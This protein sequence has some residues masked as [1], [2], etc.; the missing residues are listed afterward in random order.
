MR[1]GNVRSPNADFHLMFVDNQA[2]H[3]RSEAILHDAA[4]A[5]AGHTPI[6]HPTAQMPTREEA[7]DRIR[8][9]SRA[10]S[11]MGSV[12]Y[13]GDIFGSQG[14][15]SEG[16]MY[17]ARRRSFTGSQP[18]GSPGSPLAA[19][20]AASAQSATASSSSSSSAA[21][22]SAVSA[23][24]GSPLARGV[25]I[26]MLQ[27]AHELQQDQHRQ[28][29]GTTAAH[30]LHEHSAS[31]GSGAALQPLSDAPLHHDQHQ[32]QHQQQHPQSHPPRHPGGGTHGTSSDSASALH[33]E[34]SKRGHDHPQ[35]H[36]ASQ[37]HLQQ[38]QQ[39]QRNSRH[40][41]HESTGDSR[42]SNRDVSNTSAF[43]LEKLKSAEEVGGAKLLN[44]EFYHPSDTISAHV[45]KAL[46][47]K[48]KKQPLLGEGG[49]DHASAAAGGLFPASHHSDDSTL[50]SILSTAGMIH[51]E[52]NHGAYGG[53]IGGGHGVQGYLPV[54]AD[55][56]PSSASASVSAR[57]TPSPAE[58]DNPLVVRRYL[59]PANPRMLMPAKPITTIVLGD[60]RT[61]TGREAEAA[62]LRMASANQEVLTV[63]PTGL[64]SAPGGTQH[65][66][67]H[68]HSV[69]G[70]NS[71][72]HSGTS[73][74]TGRD[75]YSSAGTA[76]DAFDASVTDRNAPSRVHTPSG[77]SSSSAAAM[78]TAANGGI[79][80]AKQLLALQKKT[81]AMAAARRGSL[82]TGVQYSVDAPSWF[83]DIT[84]SGKVIKRMHLHPFLGIDVSVHRISPEPEVRAKAGVGKA[85]GGRRR[86][87]IA[88]SNVGEQGVLSAWSSGAA[89]HDGPTG[90]GGA[91]SSSGVAASSA[92][93]SPNSLKRHKAK[94]S[95]S[96]N[97]RVSIAAASGTD[98]ESQEQIQEFHLKALVEDLKGDRGAIGGSSSSGTKP[99]TALTGASRGYAAGAPF[100]PSES[101]N[102]NGNGGSSQSPA[103]QLEATRQQ[104][105]ADAALAARFWWDA[106]VNDNAAAAGGGRDQTVDQSHHSHQQRTDSQSPSSAAGH[107]SLLELSINNP[108]KASDAEQQQHRHDEGDQTQSSNGSP[109]SSPSSDGDDENDEGGDDGKDAQPHSQRETA[110][111]G[112][113]TSTSAGTEQSQEVDGDTDDTPKQLPY[114][115]IPGSAFSRPNSRAAASRPI[116]RGLFAA[117]SFS[118][119][120][121]AGGSTATDANSGGGG[122]SPLAASRPVTS[123]QQ[124]RLGMA[125]RGSAG[126][127][128]SPFPHQ[129]GG[130]ITIY[131]FT[132]ASM[133]GD[134]NGGRSRTK[135]R[136]SARG[137]SRG[138]VGVG[139]GGNT[140][141][142]GIGQ[143]PVGPP[144]D[145][146]PT[147]GSAS[148][149]QPHSRAVVPGLQSPSTAA[150]GGI[151]PQSSVSSIGSY[152]STGAASASASSPAS[153]L[154]GNRSQIA[155]RGAKSRRAPSRERSFLQ[156]EAIETVI[157]KRQPS[158][159]AT[160]HARAAEALRNAKTSGL[161]APELRERRQSAF[162]RLH[163][164]ASTP[165]QQAQARRRAASKEKCRSQ[166]P[167]QLQKARADAAV[168][169]GT[170]TGGTGSSSRPATK[171]QINRHSRTEVVTGIIVSRPHPVVPFRGSNKY[172]NISAQPVRDFIDGDDDD[173]GENGNGNDAN[174][175]GGM[176]PRA[177]TAGGGGGG[178]RPKRVLTADEQAA[179]NQRLTTPALIA[180]RHRAKPAT[181]DAGTGVVDEQP[182]LANPSVIS[183]GQ[184]SDLP[185][186]S[187]SVLGRSQ[188][189]PFAI[190]SMTINTRGSTAPT[191]VHAG[192]A[193]SSV[194]S[195]GSGVSV[196]T[197]SIYQQSSTFSSNSSAV[198]A[199]GYYASRAS[200]SLGSHAP[201]SNGTAGVT[202]ASLF[203]LP[204]PGGVVPGPDLPP[205]LPFAL[206]GSRLASAL[207]SPIS[208]PAGTSFFD[209]QPTIGADGHPVAATLQPFA[210]LSDAFQAKL[211]EISRSLM[212]TPV[213]SASAHVASLFAAAAASSTAS[214]AQQNGSSTAGTGAYG[215][216]L[217]PG[218]V[219]NPYS[220]YTSGS[221]GAVGVSYGTYG[222]PAVATA[223]QSAISPHTAAAAA[224]AMSSAGSAPNSLYSTPARYSAAAAAQGSA[225][226]A[227]TGAGAV[228]LAPAPVIG[229]DPSELASPTA[230]TASGG[231]SAAAPASPFALLSTTSSA[232]ASALAAPY[233]MSSANS[234]T[235]IA[236]S[237]NGV[238]TTTATDTPAGPPA[239]QHPQIH[240]QPRSASSSIP[241]SPDQLALEA[242]SRMMLNG[243]KGIADRYLA[244]RSASG[245]SS[246][247]ASASGSAAASMPG[248]R[249]A[250]GVPSMTDAGSGAAPHPGQASVVGQGQPRSLQALGSGL[251]QQGAGRGSIVATSTCAPAAAGGTSASTLNSM[252]NTKDGIAQ[253]S[254]PSGIAIG[255]TSTLYAASSTA[256]IAAATAAISP[257]QSIQGLPEDVL[258]VYS[259][260]GPRSPR[261]NGASGAGTGAGSRSPRAGGRRPQQQQQQQ[262]TSDSPPSRRGTRR[263]QQQQQ[264][265]LPELR[266][267]TAHAHLSRSQSRDHTGNCGQGS[268]GFNGPMLRRETSNST[269]GSNDISDP[270]DGGLITMQSQGGNE[271][272]GRSAKE[273]RS[274]SRSRDGSHNNRHNDN[275]YAS[276][277]GGRSAAGGL[278]LTIA[279]SSSALLASRSMHRESTPD[280]SHSN[281]SNNGMDSSQKQRVYTQLL[282]SSPF[283]AS[284]SLVP[285][286][287]AGSIQASIAAGRDTGTVL[288]PAATGTP[289]KL[290]ITGNGDDSV[291]SNGDPTLGQLRLR[292][293]RP[294]ATDVMHSVDD[295]MDEGVL[296]GSVLSPGGYNFAA[297]H[298][299]PRMHQRHAPGSVGLDR[300]EVGGRGR[301][302]TKSQG[303]SRIAAAGMTVLSSGSSSG[304]AAAGVESSSV[305]RSS[306]A[307]KPFRAGGNISGS[308]PRG[309]VHHV[310]RLGHEPAVGKD[311]SPFL[312]YKPLSGARSGLE[313]LLSRSIDDVTAFYQRADELVADARRQ[314]EI[315]D[316]VTPQK[317]IRSRSNSLVA[318]A[319]HPRQIIPPEGTGT[320]PIHSNRT[321]GRNSPVHSDARD[322]TPGAKAA[323]APAIGGDVPGSVP[324]T[325]E[326]VPGHVQVTGLVARPVYMLST[327]QQTGSSNSNSS[328]MNLIQA[329]A[330]AATRDRDRSMTLT[331][332]NNYRGSPSGRAP[333]AN[334]NGR[335][336]SPAPRQLSPQPA[337]ASPSAAGQGSPS[338]AAAAP[339]AMAVGA[340]GLSV[341]TMGSGSVTGSFRFAPVPGAQ[342][343]LAQP[344]V[345]G[346]PKGSSGMNMNGHGHVHAEEQQS[347]SHA[348]ATLMNSPAASFNRSRV[349][350][351]AA[352]PPQRQSTAIPS[353]QHQQ[354]HQQQQYP[355][356]NPMPQYGSSTG[357]IS[358]GSG[359][360]YGAGLGPQSSIASGLGSGFGM[361]SISSMATI[362]TTI[363][364]ITA[365]HRSGHHYA[366]TSAEVNADL[367][368]ASILAEQV[369]A[370]AGVNREPSSAAKQTTMRRS[371][372]TRSGPRAQLRSRAGA[373]STTKAGTRSASN[374]GTTTATEDAD[375][376]GAGDDDMQHLEDRDGSDR[377][378]IL[379]YPSPKSRQQA[380]AHE[381]ATQLQRNI[382]IVRGPSRRRLDA[383]GLHDTHQQHL[384]A[385]A[386][387]AMHDPDGSHAAEA[388]VP[389]A[390]DADARADSSSG[391]PTAA[392]SIA[393]STGAVDDDASA[394]ARPRTSPLAGQQH[395][396]HPSRLSSSPS[397]SPRNNG[398]R[399]N[400]SPAHGQ[401]LAGALSGN[402]AP[403]NLGG[404]GS[405]GVARQNPYASLVGSGINTLVS[406]PSAAAATTTPRKAGAEK[407]MD[408]SNNSQEPGSQMEGSQTQQRQSRSSQGSRRSREVAVAG[409]E[410]LHSE[411]ATKQMRPSTVP[412]SPLASSSSLTDRDRSPAGRSPRSTSAAAGGL[413]A[414]SASLGPLASGSGGAAPSVATSSP[415][416]QPA[417]SLPAG[418]QLEAPPTP[419]KASSNV[420][421]Y[422][423]PLVAG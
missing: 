115:P 423:V 178:M 26:N 353:S 311:A 49:P 393:T 123:Q 32:H 162:D 39:Q 95:L 69:V 267:G 136:G 373:G 329:T 398:T 59:P 62:A 356:L 10:G 148:Q 214:S 167:P 340:A 259:R 61:L 346:V 191:P 84:A 88:Q 157:F 75:S 365:G 384:T 345:T 294:R 288:F 153:N 114:T 186:R 12:Q 154:H 111:A 30:S 304:V 362:S 145:D 274:R 222:V 404:S 355:Q 179:L 378:A 357:G 325:S 350:K 68:R 99:G 87:I 156:P 34:H 310:H 85:G 113:E 190:N 320:S 316:R 133:G 255:P 410:S 260:G 297:H 387:A 313:G 19:A 299:G 77:T 146:S 70:H 228:T 293:P 188:S 125:S 225:V 249:S 266:V 112:L 286:G 51:E 291:N 258:R 76:I 240:L 107:H 181:A 175:Y 166:S 28:H 389:A 319:S 231:A 385:S 233:G 360:S 386:S 187:S 322:V 13:S 108:Q 279:S 142:L 90:A 8:A 327:H 52:G 268:R 9:L 223:M 183:N 290:G 120:G 402:V 247:T 302:T 94:H 43:V 160:E 328:S 248:S 202:S 239:H 42:D 359:S 44:G 106:L 278:C 74:S 232:A 79:T 40:S 370:A 173:D 158:L 298:G 306:T 380:D 200:S 119:G 143:M 375:L 321:S 170:T 122:H 135:S 242:Y 195:T 388:G 396:H 66:R 208:L 118:S 323:P 126:T 164:A 50:S 227:G 201:S 374:D 390:A 139:M 161:P 189:P 159:I 33:R 147:S 276:L 405:A 81:R 229:F 417:S 41:I 383:E 300:R 11:F 376:N 100:S 197:S 98:E 172:T 377:V 407:A 317:V 221:A 314:R 354:Q 16:R 331:S 192:L 403:V 287:S 216:P 335:G 86:S 58:L 220:P 414:S 422:R 72:P 206:P 29:V 307:T 137:V 152:G 289:S 48:T 342:P 60:G 234:P 2:A 204:S 199:G 305:H 7:L 420:S 4:E 110:P 54:S 124:Q 65:H 174:G 361:S 257:Y 103:P 71:Q 244:G 250:S 130:D 292:T 399:P 131:N 182:S 22:G 379:Q 336:T 397:A 269:D 141:G 401:A 109:G 271:R 251:V 185:S 301:S 171:A 339:A 351:R 334:G 230:P 395:Q 150:I 15:Y 46:G 82:E 363:L 217:R 337:A 134:N 421:P 392:P 309:E 262:R 236:I 128:S 224:A 252:S 21:A 176:R 210:R 237:S 24:P 367:Q 343:S 241:T 140:G 308:P 326:K 155:S 31:G 261:G 132:T 406:T 25:P 277:R 184:V 391:R 18:S 165:V 57:G 129:R 207:A 102:F 263:P 349:Q 400:T 281:S 215:T 5:A 56:G 180:N 409:T 104:S 235:M 285:L 280:T 338:A 238:V 364:N 89:A 408:A 27:S 196:A 38:H 78:A 151:G 96:I 368:Q 318:S 23:G 226:N 6:A 284:P 211:A 203:S 275:P 412:I 332:S 83:T 116:S 333:T 36:A 163:A 73:A 358:S 17:L 101:G 218:Q 80:D 341:Q 194:F 209:T 93:L 381:M 272:H 177:S 117:G 324:G 253:P 169:V 264:Q 416:Q 419:H 413:V 35:H 127:S 149:P 97:P 273:H 418:L 243:F 283:T 245:L 168:P 105:N 282:P 265:Q 53:N 303:G 63:L 14:D 344:I 45:R 67:S 312:S 254:L 3:Q 315:Q 295:D 138:G 256:A 1:N 219:S 20:A 371:N 382:D 366:P 37:R 205:G 394:A 213:G 212:S 348:P 91:S 415:L 92:P 121:G 411:A 198:A 352:S 64:S 347:I 270:F 55:A 47:L 330:T 296:L 372:I 246:T 144:V 369:L 193:Q